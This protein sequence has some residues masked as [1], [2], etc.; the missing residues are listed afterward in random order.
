MTT[1][2]TPAKRPQRDDHAL[3]ELTQRLAALLE[4]ET[5]ALV[6]R[7]ADALA[8]L[9]NEKRALTEPYALEAA[10]VREALEAAPPEARALEPELGKATRSLRNALAGNAE[11]L[12]VAQTTTQRVVEA[13]AQS[14]EARHAE[15]APYVAS[16]ARRASGAHAACPSAFAYDD[17][18]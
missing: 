5:A 14:L 2:P 13:I 6:A 3:L 1:A 11:A 18:L 4:R 10:A 12:I 16:G 17:H 9:Q 8:P 15:G 7:R